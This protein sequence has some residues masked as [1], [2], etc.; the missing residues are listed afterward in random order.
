MGLISLLSCTQKNKMTQTEIKIA[1]TIAPFVDITKQIA[2]NRVEVYS[3][4]P[5]GVN[6]HS[7]E[8]T[9]ENLKQILDANIY[10]RVGKIL[11]LESLILDK[12]GESITDVVDCSSEIELIEGN[13]HYWLAPQNIKIITENILSELIQKYPQHKNYFVN[14]RNKFLNKIDSLDKHLDKVI[15]TKKDKVL[16]VYHPAWT[17][18]A[19]Q[20][21]LE[22]IS[23]EQEG[24]S[25]KAFELTEFIE[26][27]KSK[28]VSCIFFDPHF[29]NSAVKTIAESL[30]LEIA[31]L[32]PLPT[33]YI[34][35]LE[36]IIH[37]LDKYLK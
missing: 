2:G 9:P 28:G 18:F 36:D 20:Y 3:L 13:P 29:D 27:A 8:P 34:R 35:N 26:L 6:A 17:Y 12:V 19:K 14:N 31:S 24:K 7:F 23:I 4:I 37:K 16:F 10:F 30:N 21:N 25:P 32:D 1:V 11:N 22:E 33:D 15:S 5:P